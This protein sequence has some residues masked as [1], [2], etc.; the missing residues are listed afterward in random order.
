MS[1]GWFRWDRFAFVKCCKALLEI[2]NLF[3]VA[4]YATWQFLLMAALITVE[5]VCGAFVQDHAHASTSERWCSEPIRADKIV[6]SFKLQD[7]SRSLRGEGL[8]RTSWYLE[9][10][11]ANPQLSRSL[12]SLA[13]IRAHG[14]VW[15]LWLCRNSWN[16][17]STGTRRVIMSGQMGGRQS[18]GLGEKI[19]AITVLRGSMVDARCFAQYVVCF[20][21]KPH[22][23]DF[24]SFLHFSLDRLAG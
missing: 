12:A 17:L 6:D 20:L 8:F 15:R 18:S 4:V 16:V 23:E 19:E 11:L 10:R 9:R 5:A 13:L 22:L 21:R 1:P 24:H 14:S 7:W 3:R 2:K